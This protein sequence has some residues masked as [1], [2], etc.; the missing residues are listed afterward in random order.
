ME[1]KSGES[2]QL[3]ESADFDPAS[4]TLLPGDREFCYF[5]ENRVMLGDL[6]NLKAREVYR[7]PD[8]F[9]RGRGLSVTEDGQH[10][11]IV[12]KKGAR[13]RLQ[14]IRMGTGDAAKLVECDEEIRD[15]IPRPRRASVLY[16][17]A[18]GVW[19]ANYDGQQN[20]RLRTAPGECG[21]ARWSPQGRTALYLNYPADRHKLHNIREFTP[22]TNRDQA[23]ADTTQFIDFSA[24]ADATVFVGASGS[25]ASPYVLLLVR[26][27]KR[28]MTVAMHRASDPA[29][30]EPV[31]TPNSQHVLFGSDQHGKP[32]IYAISVEKLVEETGS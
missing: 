9:E 1:L 28:E 31:F 27:V 4:L 7:I 19:L 11:A 21:P 13:H 29:I 6:R 14:L 30:V 8:G 17:R 2:R 23:V 16:R 5:D 22:D 20:Y 3:T 24:N 12:E 26:A 25:K 32:A 10:A 15:P 18:G